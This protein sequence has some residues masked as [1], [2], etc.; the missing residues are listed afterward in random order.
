MNMDDVVSYKKESCVNLFEIN[1]GSS[2]IYGSLEHEGVPI[3]FDQVKDKLFLPPQQNFFFGFMERKL[4]EDQ[5]APAE[6]KVLEELYTYKKRIKQVYEALEDGLEKIKKL[7][8]EFTEKIHAGKTNRKA[9]KSVA[10]VSPE[11]VAQT[12]VNASIENLK[13]IK[14]T[15]KAIL[16]PFHRLCDDWAVVRNH[17]HTLEQS[18]KQTRVWQYFPIDDLK[19]IE[20]QISDFFKNMSLTIPEHPIYKFGML[21]KRIINALIS[22]NIAIDRNETTEEFEREVKTSISKFLLIEIIELRKPLETRDPDFY[23]QIQEFR[24]AII[25]NHP[26]YRDSLQLFNSR[27]FDYLTNHFVLAC[28]KAYKEGKQNKLKEFLEESSL[29][30]KEIIDW[31]EKEDCLINNYIQEIRDKLSAEHLPENVIHRIVCYFKFPDYMKK[32]SHL[33][34]FCTNT[35]IKKMRSLSFDRDSEVE[36]APECCLGAKDLL[37]TNS[38]LRAFVL[39]DCDTQ[40][41]LLDFDRTHHALEQVKESLT[42]FFED[43]NSFSLEDAAK[44]LLESVEAF[45]LAL[46]HPMDNELEI[47]HVRFNFSLEVT[48]EM[49][50]LLQFKMGTN[51]TFQSIHNEF[52]SENPF[53]VKEMFSNSNISSSKIYFHWAELSSIDS[54]NIL[55]ASQSFCG[56]FDLHFEE[57]SLEAILKVLEDPSLD[58][59]KDFNLRQKYIEKVLRNE[60]TQYYQE[61]KSLITE[62]CES[63]QKKYREFPDV[64]N[65]LTGW[66]FMGRK[67]QSDDLEPYLDSI[68]LKSF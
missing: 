27:F 23:K 43:R 63:I 42:P 34:L 20:K 6:K 24:G 59:K 67:S 40:N 41:G 5:L 21:K 44:I 60:L 35:E 51:K 11:S 33:D 45:Y 31:V 58:Q 47:E 30:I 50:F 4:P 8:L 68:V 7:V 46:L 36:N 12:L 10:S 38:D 61:G 55:I 15:R 13:T 26:L 32:F 17:L 48:N 18:L 19:K 53:Q 57:S 14:S 25:L 37:L 64:K 52:T 29:A 3:P 54:H 9:W 66:E 16:A 28:I 2:L 65:Q 56:I 39:V 22:L 62:I 1:F 49:N